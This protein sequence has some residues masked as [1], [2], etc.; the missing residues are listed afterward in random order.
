M[1]TKLILFL[2][3]LGC[4]LNAAPVWKAAAAKAVITPE[5]KL[6]MAGYASRKTGAEGK[7]QD[8]FAK[9]LVVEDESGARMVIIT[10]D[11]IGV[12]RPFRLAMEKEVCAK[13]KLPP[14][15]LL[16]NASHTHSGPMIRVVR[17]IGKGALARPATASYD[18]I[19]TDQEARRVAETL[20]YMAKLQTTLI[21]LIGECIKNLQPA[22]LAYSHARC[23]FAMNR[24]LPVKG[25]FRNSPYPDGP[26]DHDVPVLQVRSADG[27]MLGILF[28]YACHNTTTGTMQF[29]GDYAGWAQE[30]LEA[31]NPGAVA[32][33]VAG[34]G[35]DQNP[36][37]RGTLELAKKHGRTLATAVE[38][39]L[40]ANPEAVTGPLRAAMNYVSIDY[41]PP[42][43]RAQLEAKA[44]SRDRYDRR[45]AE[46]L[47]EILDA[48]GALPKNYPVPVQVIHFGQQLTMITLGGEVVVDYSL[49]LKRELGKNHA[50]WV[51]GYSN[52]V[53]TYIPSL[54]VL[55]EGGYEGG[56]AMRYVRSNPHPSHWAETIEK[57]LVDRIHALDKRLRTL[58]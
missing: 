32:L 23:G 12:P 43:T 1:K 29:N 42:P 53:M 22:K 58:K 5:K 10:L 50:V 51:A 27:K 21:G 6:W 25:R 11:L 33:F 16:L 52:D 34:C 48:E 7:L 14:S 54:R 26:V 13:F 2:A 19:P 49:R 20:A 38:A 35:G 30:Y 17:P 3:F 15:H 45:H 37:P 55:R 57:R 46:A 4:A 56:G 9:A 40:I 47:L 41:A 36:Y 39:G 31:D 44:K 8:L 24:R 18:N 28:G